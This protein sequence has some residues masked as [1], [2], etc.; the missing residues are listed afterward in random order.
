[1]RSAVA[2]LA[3]FLV[4]CAAP[5]MVAD[6]GAGGVAFTWDEIALPA[7]ATDRTYELRVW[8]EEQG[9]PRNEVLSADGLTSAQWRSPTPLPSAL[10][11]WSVRARY[12]RGG[13]PCASPWRGEDRSAVVP[14]RRLARFEVK[15][16]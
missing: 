14:P 11:Q 4:S 16:P 9:L 12:F 3:L 2:A 8:T 5:S 13:R 15:S 6:A 7:D 10:Y 1:M